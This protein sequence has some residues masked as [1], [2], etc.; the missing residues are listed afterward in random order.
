MQCEYANV[1]LSCR[2]VQEAF[3]KDSNQK[4]DMKEALLAIEKL[5]GEGRKAE[6]LNNIIKQF[7]SF[8]H[9]GRHELHPPIAINRRDA[10]FDGNW[11]V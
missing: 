1:L 10:E 8:L 6:K 2:K 7:A 5:L 4:E 3:V 11:R 9:L